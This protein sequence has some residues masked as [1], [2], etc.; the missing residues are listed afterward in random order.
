MNS[1][2][3]NR[4]KEVTVELEQPLEMENFGLSE[5]DNAN[6]NDN[7]NA[8]V[9]NI[10]KDHGTENDDGNDVNEGCNEVYLPSNDKNLLELMWKAMQENRKED[11]AEQERIRRDIERN[12]KEDRE[13][14][15]QLIGKFGEKVEK[16]RESLSDECERRVNKV[17]ED[18]TKLGNK[19][20][21]SIIAVN[22]KFREVEEIQGRQMSEAKVRHAA[23]E[24]I[25]S[26]HKTL[27]LV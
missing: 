2:E 23:I 22:N 24:T 12:R 17:A 13:R 11:K 3:L 25:L 19:T 9:N 7:D 16:I 5:N 27:K 20:E 1:D 4:Q 21:D 6:V 26:E 15:E 14:L 8:N 10:D 18:V